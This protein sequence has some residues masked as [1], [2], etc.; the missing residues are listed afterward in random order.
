MP[1]VLLGGLVLGLW[2]LRSRAVAAAPAGTLAQQV[3][4]VLMGGTAAAQSAAIMAYEAS[5]GLPQTGLY[6]DAVRDALVDDGIANP[7]P[8][9]TGMDDS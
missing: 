6:T 5:K 8:T 4:A 2:W 7:P 3:V 9:A 1:F